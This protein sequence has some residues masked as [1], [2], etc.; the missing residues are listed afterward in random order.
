[1]FCN[2]V[3]KAAEFAFGSDFEGQLAETQGSP[4]RVVLTADVGA[5][6]APLAFYALLSDPH[7]VEIVDVIQDEAGPEAFVDDADG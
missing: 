6:P 1:M 2:T 7:T 5:F 3:L 4:I